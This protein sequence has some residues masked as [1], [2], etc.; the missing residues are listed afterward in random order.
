LPPAGQHTKSSYS[1]TPLKSNYFHKVRFGY[2]NWSEIKHELGESK[3][4]GEIEA[5]YELLFN[6]SDQSLPVIIE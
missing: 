6:N 4:L 5:H 1:S 3:T 2:G